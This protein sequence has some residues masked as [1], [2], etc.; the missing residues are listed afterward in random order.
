MA[1]RAIWRAVLRVGSA[2]VPVKLYAAVQDRTVHFD[3]L[4]ART[5]ARIKQQMT[6]PGTGEEVPTAAVRKGYE[7]EPGTFVVLSDAE[8]ASLDPEPSREIRIS[9]FL[10]IGQINH[11][12][13]ERPYYLGPDGDEVAYFALAGALGSREREGLAH[14]VMR[15]RQCHGALRVHDGRL[16]LIAL[17]NVEE[18]LAAGELP[19]VRGRPLDP[20]ELELARQLVATLE[21]EFRPGDFRDEYRARVQELVAAK[22]RHERPRLRPVKTRRPP[23]SLLDTLARSVES[24][25]QRRGAARG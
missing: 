2:S 17:R 7:V 16:V 20:K 24:A 10:P 5:L 4:E 19:A 9:R 15:K 13:Y 14:W 12:W 22:A 23:R 1:A 25:R 21:G 8:L 3:L 11:Q 6:D 18:V